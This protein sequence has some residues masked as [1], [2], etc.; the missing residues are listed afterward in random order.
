MYGVIK[1]ERD[2][3]KSDNLELRR[4]TKCGLQMDEAPVKPVLDPATSK[5]V[6]NSFSDF[7]TSVKTNFD[8]LP[9]PGNLPNQVIN[10]FTKSA[11]KPIRKPLILTTGATPISFSAFSEKLLPPM[12]VQSV[13]SI[14]SSIGSFTTAPKQP[15]TAILNAPEHLLGE[16]P[17]PKP[18]DIPSRKVESKG[19]EIFNIRKRKSTE[20]EDSSDGNEF[21][22]KV[23]RVD[24]FCQTASAIDSL[25][26]DKVRF[27]DITAS[28]NSTSK[29]STSKM[30]VSKKV[31][32]VKKSSHLK[33]QVQKLQSIKKRDFTRKYFNQL[34][35]YR[36]LKKLLF[37]KNR[38]L[39]EK[40]QLL[41]AVQV[42]IGVL[43]NNQKIVA[44]KLK[45]SGENK[46]TQES[47]SVLE[48]ERERQRER[49]VTLDRINEEQKAS[50]ASKRRKISLD[51]N[52]SCSS[53]D[54][55]S[56]DSSDIAEP[57]KTLPKSVT[58]EKVDKTSS[59]HRKPEAKDKIP[60]E[61]IVRPRIRKLI[62]RKPV[63]KPATEQTNNNQ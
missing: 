6:S 41:D 60:V 19:L 55:I 58:T 10:P 4:L 44:R 9:K 42:T 38:T 34:K 21:L 1:I 23:S 17:T 8:S 26:F 3:L 54:L 37:N 7:T 28:K 31:L 43:K 2:Q 59:E 27:F 14:G 13:I 56:D 61:P 16:M 25:K 46:K 40:N 15:Q 24:V 47:S 53:A 63:I 52:E 30:S 50:K 12:S 49:Q 39:D 22:R 20:S 32:S 29:N 36:I 51:K 35:K 18:L 48:F 33:Y 45:A 5:P 62:R 57:L 11:D